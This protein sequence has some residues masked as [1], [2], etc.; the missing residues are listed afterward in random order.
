MTFP[1]T[2]DHFLAGRLR[3]L[4]PARGHRVGTDAALLQSAV[5]PAFAGEVADLGAGVGAVGLSVAVRAPLARVTLVEKDPAIAALARA[6]VDRNALSAR[7]VVVEADVTLAGAARIAVGLADRSVDLILTNPPFHDARRIRRSPDAYRAAAHGGGPALLDAWLRSA[8]AMLRPGGDL[9]LIHRADA[10]PALLA[11]VAGRFGAV[12]VLPVLPRAG[13]D[14]TRVLLRA[15]KG[16]RTPFR[17]LAPLILHG[18]GE[19]FT[20]LAEALHAGQSDLVWDGV[21]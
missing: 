12:R 21:A 19:R 1:T 16:S 9:V 4:Q 17:L 8:A 11:G 20:A 15:T 7:V 13:A 5:A 10:L 3:L 18:E 14:A 2:D 6:N